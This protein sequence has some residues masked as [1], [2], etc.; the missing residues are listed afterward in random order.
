[1]ESL[2]KI[3]G[4]EEMAE[5]GGFQADIFKKNRDDNSPSLPKRERGGNEM[6]L[7]HVIRRRKKSRQNIVGRRRL[8]RS[9]AMLK[10]DE[11]AKND[12]FL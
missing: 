9:G 4:E 2:G 8:L 10:Y 7:V 3:G 5:K 1:V 11:S 12:E 6:R